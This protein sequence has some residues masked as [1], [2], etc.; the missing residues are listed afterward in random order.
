MSTNIFAHR[1]GTKAK[2]TDGKTIIT[3]EWEYRRSCDNFAVRLDS[4]DPITGRQRMFVVY[5]D[6]P[7][8]GKFKLIK[9]EN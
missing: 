5:D 8:W 7:E 2:W 9:K 4:T 3:G 6:T 1:P